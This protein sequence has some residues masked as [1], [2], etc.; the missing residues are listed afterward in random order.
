MPPLE[1]S[2]RFL[3]S[4]RGRIVARL[5]RGS[6]T[7]EAL[8]AEVGLSENGV[9]LHLAT[10][11]KDGWISAEGLRRV[12]GP[13]K[14]ATLYG[15]APGAPALLSTAYRPLL[16]ALLGALGRR[17][18]P[19]RRQELLRAAGRQLA[20]ELKD[21]GAGRAEQRAIA[22]LEALG[23][24]VRLEPGRGGGFAL[25]GQGCPLEE[26]VAVEPKVCQAMSALLA[27]AL[28][29]TVEERCDRTSPPCCRFE[30]SVRR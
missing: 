23:A 9:R 24:E 18:G 25:V 4:T 11:E 12:A 16:L 13:G 26:A 21:G 1:W 7:V 8:A 29:A 27:G 3:A 14:P 20:A 5:R 28:D 22:L 10:L 2:R 17:E 30:V 6:A 19:R 15:I